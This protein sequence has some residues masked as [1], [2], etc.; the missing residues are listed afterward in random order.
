MKKYFAIIAAALLCPLSLAAQN[1]PIDVQELTL[2]NG[3]QV[4]L[5]RDASQPKVYG[6]VVV[7]AGGK[8]CPD[9]GLA[10]Y[11]EHLLFK[12]TTELGTVDYEAEKVWLDSI[13]L[14]YNRLAETKDDSTRFVIQKEINRLSI[15][16]AD[17]AIPNEFDLLT[18]RFGGT[19]LNAATSYDYTFYFNTF[20]PQYM[21][22]WCELNSHRMLQPVFRLFQGELET[23]YEEKNRSADNTM[24]APLFEMIRVFSEGSPYSYEVIGSTENLKNPRLGEM[25]DFF[26]KYY[27]GN[28][29][30]LILSGDIGDT[31]TLIPLLESTFARIPE[32]EPVVKEPVR[33]PLIKG[34]RNVKIKAEIPLIKIAVYGFNGPKEGDPDAPVLDLATSLL[35]NSFSSGLLDSLITNH[36]VL[37]AGASRVP[38]FGEMGIAGYMVIPSIPFGSLSKSEKLVREQIEKIKAGQFSDSDLEALKLEAARNA[39]IS[40]ETI[41]ARSSQMVDVMTQN[42]SWAEYL[43][44]VDAIRSIT[45][46]DV[47]RVANKY[48]GDDYIRFE[49]VNGTYPK[50]KVAAPKFDPIVP[51]HAG[52]KSEYAKRLEAM[53]VADVEPRLLDFQNDVERLHLAQGVTLLYKANELNDVFSLEIRVDE[54]SVEDPLIPHV[55]SYLGTLGTDSL[56][57]QQL[58]KAWQHLGTNFGVSSDNHS[59]S[60][61]LMGFD[62]Y[63]EPSLK[64]LRHFEDHVTPDKAGFKELRSSI[65]LEKKTFLTGGTSNIMQAT[66]QRVLYG[67]NSSYLRGLSSKE[68]GKI[69]AKGLL[70]KFSELL[71]KE[72]TILYCGSLPKETVAK[73]LGEQ[74]DLARASC[75]TA[76]KFPSYEKYDEPTVFFYNL[77][78]SRQTQMMS[79]QTFDAPADGTQTALLEMLGEYIGGGMYSLMFQEVREFRAMAYSAYGRTVRPIPADKD[80]SAVL[81]TSLGTQADKSLSAIQ[82]VDSLLNV[83][84]LKESTLVASAQSLVAGANNSYPSFR[85]VAGSIHTNEVRG[86]T[87]DPDKAVLEHLDEVTTESLKAYYDSVVLPSNRSWIIVGDRSLLPM[88]EIAKFGKIVELTQKDIYK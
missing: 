76:C 75:K 64:L 8:D 70:D 3:M 33:A 69:G 56:S 81:F 84:P 21:A 60:M 36:K 79:Y 4:W 62:E 13:A 86:Y 10:H 37:M 25:M 26:K 88:D 32:G 82:L 50:D 77:P 63:L 67:E 12:G 40:T 48:F 55:A 61:N 2:S 42:R 29:M 51:K 34:S 17:Y 57:I 52:E 66:S 49:K 46:E 44:E 47:I 74:L 73:V 9:T 68:I 80:Q 38:L 45:R 11:L 59:F 1:S 43:A 20:S 5:N 27:V 7:K 18:A 41:D 39:L 78:G 24:Q 23:V 19:G 53:P 28:N 6:A 71:D 35:S 31:E 30:G 14:C 22:Q 87:E 54:G 83:L 72:C 65:D 16:A 15:K 85:G 58:S